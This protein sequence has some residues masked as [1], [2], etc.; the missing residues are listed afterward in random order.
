MYPIPLK[1]NH[2]KNYRQ[3]PLPTKAVKK[4]LEE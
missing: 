4:I 2:V 3:F 1:F